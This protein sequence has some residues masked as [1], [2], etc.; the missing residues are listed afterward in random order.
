MAR[1]RS[2]VNRFSGRINQTSLFHRWHVR[3]SA[4]THA[5]FVALDLINVRD[6]FTHR[7]VQKW[8]LSVQ[9]VLEGCGC[10]C[11]RWCSASFQVLRLTQGGLWC[12]RGPLWRDVRGGLCLLVILEAV[13]K[14]VFC[15]SWRGVLASGWVL[16]GSA[17]GSWGDGGGSSKLPPR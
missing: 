3:P 8:S 13:V 5:G 1:C 17:K 2:G 11:L 16:P 7:H 9:T 12:S 15:S 4:L 10:G 14:G 6:M